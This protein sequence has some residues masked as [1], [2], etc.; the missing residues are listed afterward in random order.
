MLSVREFCNLIAEYKKTTFNKWWAVLGGGYLFFAFFVT[1]HCNARM[2][3]PLF[4]PYIALVVYGIFMADII[5]DKL[6]S[7]IISNEFLLMLV[8]PS[9]KLL[10]LLKTSLVLA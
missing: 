10:R 9:S 8:H 2:T 5:Q 4:A 3:L 6:L 7:G 1:T